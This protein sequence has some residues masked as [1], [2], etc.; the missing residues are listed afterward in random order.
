MKAIFAKPRRSTLG[1]LIVSVALCW[2]LSGLTV[3]PDASAQIQF[4]ARSVSLNNPDGSFQHT[5]GAHPDL[6]VYLKMP[7]PSEMLHDVRL[8]LPPGFVG[9]QTAV[10]ECSIDEFR[11][12]FNPSFPQCAVTTQIGWARP[13]TTATGFPVPVYSLVHGP[14]LPARFG[15]TFANASVFIDVAVRPG[16]YQISSASNNTTQYEHVNEVE[17]DLWGVPADPAHDAERNTPLP[18]GLP[19]RP[20]LRNPTSCSEQASPFT[21]EVDSWESRGDFYVA[22][23]AADANGVPFVFEG[24]E[25]L[26]FA[27]S[28]SARTTSS[29]PDSP[30]GLVVDLDVPQNETAKGQ[31]TSDVRKVVTKLPAGLSISPSSA[32]GLASCSE[33]EIGIGGNAPPSCPAASAIGTVKI[34]TPLLT[35]ELEGNVYLARQGEN[36]FGSLFA[37]YLAAK[38]PGFYVK[39]PG[40]I[41]AD[42]STGQLT[43]TFSDT[44][45]LPFD[46]LRLELKSGPRAPLATPQSC[47][48]FTTAGILTPWSGNPDVTSTSSFA[49]GG[50]PAAAP[51]APSFSAGTTVAK[52]GA[53]SPLSVTVKRDDGEQGLA[54]VKVDMPKGVLGKIASVTPCG[55]ADANAGTCPDASRIGS[56]TVGAG[57]GAQPLYLPEPGKREDPV[58][59]TGP[60]NGGPYGL[61]IVTHAEAG[62]FNLGDVVVRASIR[63]DP[64]TAQVSVVSDPLPQIREGIPLRLRMIHVSIDRPGFIF[65]PTN[66]SQQHVTGAITSDAGV[67]ASVSSSFVAGN[68]AGLKFAPK[69]TASTTGS[70]KGNART[71]G[72]RLSVKLSYPNAPAGTQAN[73][74]KVK[75]SLPK[76]LPSR[77]LTLQKACLEAVFDANPASCPAGSVVGHAKVVTPLLSTPLTGPAYFVSHGGEAFPSLVMVLQGSGVTVQLVGKT[78]ISKAGI[79]ST[80]FDSVPDV[81]FSTFELELPQGKFS[82]LAVNGSLCAKRLLMPTDYVAQNGVTLHKNTVISAAGCPKAKKAKRAGRKHARKR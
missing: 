70:G 37:I 6:R 81:P 69:F 39:V 29:A 63:I 44:P 58:Y 52:A 25:H 17:L 12:A 7:N 22:S 51:F 73:V 56:V 20:F 41:D 30:S 78:F 76:Q 33:A 65:N 82:A 8:D 62:P 72:A 67:V 13:H 26:P 10:G 77:L 31:S 21:L 19:Q 48:S 55:E 35:E 1:R 60:Y 71:R 24:C 79:T 28:M 53:F 3:V 64:L 40:K 5:A 68:C 38:G 80:T 34:K 2:M 75:V 50:C 43:A 47:G 59:L 14:N 11:D 18:A 46:H 54:R 32:S 66:C 9:N 49:I 36:P 15:F 4:E 16:D 57:P 42:P 74:A 61:S 45:Q 27:P 23:L